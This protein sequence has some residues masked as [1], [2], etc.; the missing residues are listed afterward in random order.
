MEDGR[1]V[2]TESRAEDPKFSLTMFFDFNRVVH[3]ALQWP[4]RDTAL[5][6]R[7]FIRVELTAG[8]FLSSA[9]LHT[10][11]VMGEI[12]NL[13]A[14]K[15]GADSAVALVP[16]IL[17]HLVLLAHQYARILVQLQLEPLILDTSSFYKALI[18][19]DARQFIS[20]NILIYEGDL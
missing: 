7:I 16:L 3:R 14:S 9:S 11:P 20:F 15:P 8:G 2:R 10:D 6:Y 5:R 18:H 17:V 19:H 13:T 12:I 1:P 4:S